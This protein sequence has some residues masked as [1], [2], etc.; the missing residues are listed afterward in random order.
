MSYFQQFRFDFNRFLKTTFCDKERGVFF[1]LS[2]WVRSMLD[3]LFYHLPISF[4]SVFRV[5]HSEFPIPN[6]PISNPPPSSTLPLRYAPC[7]MRSL[8]AG[9]CLIHSAFPIPKSQIPNRKIPSFFS[10]F[11]VP[12][13]GCF[14]D[15]GQIW[16]S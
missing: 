3:V 16:S 15:H 4:F 13:G 11:S 8:R 7:P 5:P 6:L 2:K 14:H 12:L 1:E 10:T 9:G